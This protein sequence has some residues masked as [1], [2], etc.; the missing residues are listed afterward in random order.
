MYGDGE[1]RRLRPAVLAQKHHNFPVDRT[2]ETMTRKA[3]RKKKT[4]IIAGTGK[5]IVCGET[6]AK[7]IGLEKGDKN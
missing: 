5:E 6:G 2:P 4:R 7:E 3:P 1:G